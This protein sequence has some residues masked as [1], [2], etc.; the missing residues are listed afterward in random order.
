MGGAAGG[1]AIAT[2]VAVVAV[3]AAA[4]RELGAAGAAHLDLGQLGAWLDDGCDELF[5]VEVRRLGQLGALEN[6]LTLGNQSRLELVPG[7][8]ADVTDDLRVLEYRHD[9]LARQLTECTL[10]RERSAAWRS[11][12]DGDQDD[13]ASQHDSPLLGL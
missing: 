1:T 10:D 5:D 13:S 3:V 9:L 12:H 11:R 2:G 7:R 4:G 8:H 6:Q